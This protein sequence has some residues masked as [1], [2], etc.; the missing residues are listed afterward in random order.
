MPLL[1][2][3]TTFL[4]ALPLRVRNLPKLHAGEHL[5]HVLQPHH[6]AVSGLRATQW[7]RQS[8]T[9]QGGRVQGFQR[10]IKAWIID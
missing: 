8:V 6:L 5:G 9:V 2:R 1:R 7:I 3:T 10:H 4:L